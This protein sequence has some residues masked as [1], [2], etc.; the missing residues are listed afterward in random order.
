MPK[1]SLA[2]DSPSLIHA[3]QHQHVE[4]QAGGGMWGG[5]QVLLGVWVQGWLWTRVWCGQLER[6]WR[7]CVGSQQDGEG[8]VE[9]ERPS[10]NSSFWVWACTV[11]SSITTKKW[12]F[13]T[14][15]WE[16]KL[17]FLC[18]PGST[19][20]RFTCT[21]EKMQADPAQLDGLL[22]YGFNSVQL[23]FI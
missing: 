22:L 8:R 21:A 12:S 7:E 4:S 5:L 17:I 11:I 10:H 13:L 14:P 23:S 18:I 3:W 1:L 16:N 9:G 6:V 2:L 19:K 15:G 20:D